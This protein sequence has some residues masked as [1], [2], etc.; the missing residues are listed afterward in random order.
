M[1]EGILGAAV[2]VIANLAYGSMA[3]TGEQGFRR[4]AAFWLGWPGT[5]VSYMVIKPT[6]RMSEP[7]MDPRYQEQLELKEERDLLLEIRR[8]RARQISRGQ[9]EDEG[10]VEEEA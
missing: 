6:R 3:R 8:D 5:F 7:Q 2:W 9:R 10:S 4:L 1:L